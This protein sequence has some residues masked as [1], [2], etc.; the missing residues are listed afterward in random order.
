MQIVE[1][2]KSECGNPDHLHYDHRWPG[3]EVR[4]VWN[5]I[6]AHRIFSVMRNF[7][8]HT[9]Q[10]EHCGENCVLFLTDFICIG[11]MGMKEVQFRQLCV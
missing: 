1:V 9:R 5:I 8:A 4:N 3:D 2:S 6:C 7:G 11:E 10:F